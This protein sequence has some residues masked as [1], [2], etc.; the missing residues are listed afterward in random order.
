MVAISFLA[1]MVLV[2]GLGYFLNFSHIKQNM[3]FSMVEDILKKEVL[4]N[5][6]DIKLQQNL[7]M[8][9]HQMERYEEAIIAYEKIIYLEPEQAMSLNNLA[10]LLLTASDDELRN[11]RRALD[12]AKKAVDLERSPIFLDTLAEAYFRNG[13][14]QEAL[15][16]IDEA[17]FLATENRAYYKKQLEKFLEAENDI[18]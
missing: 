6:K 18:L 9:Y 4:E 16:T 14:I 5:P 8:I 7:A 13:M 3:V 12:L 2:A 11:E 10:W 15:N 17:I 1:Y